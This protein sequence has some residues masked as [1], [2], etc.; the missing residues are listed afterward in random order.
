MSPEETAAK[1]A[2]AVSQLTSR[3]MLDPATYA[4]GA[5][6]GFN[7]I[8][9]YVAG[10][11]G[12]LGDVDADVVAAAFVFFNPVTIR[13]Q[14]EVAGKVMSRHEAA[15]A[16]AGCLERWSERVPEAIDCA[17]LADLTERIVDAANPAGSPIFAAWRRLAVPDGAAARACHH[18]NALR[19][20]RLSMHGAA[21][22]AQGLRPI[23]ALAYKTPF[24][25]QIFGWDGELPDVSDC[26]P[27]WDAAEA[28]T[29]VAMAHA[30]DVL[31]PGERATFAELSRAVLDATA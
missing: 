25:A 4:Y 10:R 7:G 26:G 17:Q 29:D 6:L 19:E 3:F 9:F 28:A 14:W 18:M 30:F 13:A 24:M 27:R 15:V 8:D 11:G 5:E 31:D 21:V 20:L 1:S 2:A 12:V 16:F 23:E 22:L